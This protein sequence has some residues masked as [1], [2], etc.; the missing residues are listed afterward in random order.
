MTSPALDQQ[1]YT[2]ANLPY[3]VISTPSNPKPRCAVA[4]GSHAIDL[5]AYAKPGRFFDL[6]SGHN[7]MLAQ[8]FS[9]PALN[10]FAAL[11]WPTRRAV[12]QQLQDELKAGKVPA[13]CLV[14][15]S[16]VKNHVPMKMGGF[17]DFYT[18]LEHCQNCSGEMTSAAIAKNWWY[19]PSVY[20]SRVSSVL[21]SP[22]DIPR[23]KNVYFSNGVDSEP[24][25]GPTQKMDFELEMGY[26]VSKPVPFG[27]SMPIADAKEHVF[28]FVMLNDWSA[29]DHQLFEMRPLGPFH[30]KGFGTSISNWV[31]PMEALEEFS[32]PPNTKQDP[33]PFPHLT[34]PGQGD[35]ALDIKLRI[36][37][38][39][40]GQ[41]KELGTSNLKYLYWTP[42]QQ[43]THHA[44]SGCG[45]ETGDLI[46]TGT[47]SGSGRNEKGEK[48]ELGCLYE[49]E[50][51][52]TQVM[53]QSTGSKYQ[54]GYIEDGDEIILEGWCENKQGE[55]VLGFGECRGRI[56]PPR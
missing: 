46:G 23:P 51:T 43:L 55:V 32:C 27:E 1:P 22:H 36:R 24:T 4:I 52:K 10:S 2:L 11:P 54:E 29:R 39:R 45:M 20:N 40:N 18:S 47:I 6:E 41:E 50:R 19:A 53:P 30:S 37:L 13:E 49:G 44:A 33:A 21:P 34:W 9:E 31:V 42:Y 7:F 12:R 35:G 25:Y 56:Q 14:S 8:I 38:N 28:G 15:L 48:C 3:G 26:F 16:E 17:S 5:A